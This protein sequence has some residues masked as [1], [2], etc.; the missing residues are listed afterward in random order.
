LAKYLPLKSQGHIYEAYHHRHLDQRTNYS[1]KCCPGID[2]EYCGGSAM[3]PRNL[4]KADG[5]G[6]LQQFLF[7]SKAAWS[8]SSTIRRSGLPLN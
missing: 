6:R 5:N 3:P 2:A 8:A 1:S 4:G 7:P